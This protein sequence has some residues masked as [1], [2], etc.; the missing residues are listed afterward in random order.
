[1][2][3]V[4]QA[5]SRERPKPRA[6][7][8]RQRPELHRAARQRI[9]AMR[10]ARMPMHA[11]DDDVEACSRP[12]TPSSQSRSAR[13]RRRAP[14][15]PADT[16][17]AQAYAP[18]RRAPRDRFPREHARSAARWQARLRRAAPPD[19][20]RSPLPYAPPAKATPTAARSPARATPVR[21]VPSRAPPAP[22]A[23]ARPFNPSRIGASPRSSSARRSSATAIAAR[24]AAASAAGSARCAARVC[25]WRPH[26]SP[27]P[28]FSKGDVDEGSDSRDAASALAPS[29]SAPPAHGRRAIG[30]AH[31]SDR[32]HASDVASAAHDAAAAEARM[33]RTRAWA[34]AGS[35]RTMGQQPAAACGRGT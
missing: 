24:N 6:G 27:L 20:A 1:M 35:G 21:A 30:A 7:I 34:R 13:A 12:S 15:I 26:P 31:R 11:A 4:V 18:A 19:R 29:P 16:A 8:G 3:S 10:H 28:L 17:G 14:R 32:G 9:E 25:A 23:P 22:A 2:T 33:A 5:V